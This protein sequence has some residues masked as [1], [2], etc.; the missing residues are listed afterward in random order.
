MTQ[1]QQTEWSK[2]AGVALIL[3]LLVVALVAAIAV[4]LS[5]KFDLSVTRSA[6][7]WYGVQ[8]DAY[9]L[10][11]EE[12]GVF[13]LE[14][15]ADEDSQDGILSDT[16]TEI[17]ATSQQFPT[18]EGWLRASLEDAQGRFNINALVKKA[19]KPNGNKTPAPWQ[20]WTAAQRRFIRLLQTIEIEP[21]VYMDQQV[22]M[23]LTEAV[24]DWV[25]KDSKVTGFGGAES[26][27]YGQLEPPFV[28]ANRPMISVSELNIIRGMTPQLYQ[29]LLPLV[30]AL[31]DEEATLN[32]NTM[33]FELIRTINS[34]TELYPST[35]DDAQYIFEERG[36]GFDDIEAFKTS[37]AVDQVVGGGGGNTNLD[38]DGLG[39][40]SKYF[41]MFGDTAVGETIRQRKTL[42]HREG[43]KVT[44]LRRTDANF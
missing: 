12:V 3:A 7:R 34:K 18:D 29:A 38:T 31:P 43:N 23:S 21:E 22:A 44:I 27:Y 26:D 17:W 5:W 13:L 41:L 1:L 28:I 9:L 30:I 8:A 42:M 16:L 4:E 11:A 25:D 39:V 37:G 40:A 15:D 32:V 36:A 2:Q 24:I 14:T 6:N 19:Q 35:V 10:G 20:K 33:P